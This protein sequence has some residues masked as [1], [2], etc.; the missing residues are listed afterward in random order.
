MKMTQK[1]KDD[2]EMFLAGSLATSA[3]F[4]AFILIVEAF[5]L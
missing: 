2:L 4:I 1:S 3:L 5:C